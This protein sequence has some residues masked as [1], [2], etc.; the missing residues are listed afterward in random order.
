MSGIVGLQPMDI[1]PEAGQ[2][3]GVADPEA[4]PQ[5]ILADNLAAV[6]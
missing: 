6:P 1:D 5:E 3:E 4:L 2:Q